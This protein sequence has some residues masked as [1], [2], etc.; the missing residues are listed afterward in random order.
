MI[1]SNIL[2]VFTQSE[3]SRLITDEENCLVCQ[4][5]GSFTC[6]AGGAYFMSNIPFKGSN[7]SLKK[8]PLWWKNTV[9]SAGFT[10][11]ALGIYRAGEG[12]LWNKDIKYKN[13]GFLG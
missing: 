6:L 8:N 4:I 5:M 9:K 7:E 2:G 11:F 12:W 1:P 3:E 10:L 13:T